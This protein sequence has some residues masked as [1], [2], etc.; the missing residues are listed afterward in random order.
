VPSSG[1]AGL[2]A[3]LFVIKGAISMKLKNHPRL[4]ESLV[5]VVLGSS[6]VL[7]LSL[8]Q[9]Q[10]VPRS[11]YM[12]DNTP[13]SQG[14]NAPNVEGGDDLQGVND[15]LDGTILGSDLAGNIDICTAGNF[16]LGGLANFQ[17]KVNMLCGMNVTAEV[18]T[19]TSSY[20]FL[21][22]NS[23]W[24]SDGAA[25]HISI[26][27]MKMDREG[28]SAANHRTAGAGLKHGDVDHRHREWP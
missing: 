18:G 1:S 4:V 22:S 14:F 5:F 13:G 19:F 26:T 16:T 11:P 10:M 20:S 7:T 25:N 23:F 8:A 3:K 9:G 21:G 27:S 17:N 6:V 28:V 24:V 2:A 15:I 12:F